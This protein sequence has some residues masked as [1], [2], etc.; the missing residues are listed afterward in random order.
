MKTYLQGTNKPDELNLKFK[1]LEDKVALQE[2]R[3]K[4]CLKIKKN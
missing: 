3:E 4:E 2:Q 1:Q